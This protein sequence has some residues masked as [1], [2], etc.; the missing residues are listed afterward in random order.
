MSIKGDFLDMT[1]LKNKIHA[2]GAQIRK[3]AKTAD[4]KADEI[5]NTLAEMDHSDQIKAIADLDNFVTQH[6]SLCMRSLAKID[7]ALA[8]CEQEMI[9][10]QVIFS[11]LFS[12][13][14]YQ[15]RKKSDSKK[16]S[17]SELSFNP[18]VK[19]W[20]I[21]FQTLSYKVLG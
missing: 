6:E 19:R 3:F 20:V 10:K 15:F 4:I 18:T 2:L 17:K 8:E 12:L 11:C 13:L 21:Y 16:E 1:S 7:D 5:I 14:I 9:N